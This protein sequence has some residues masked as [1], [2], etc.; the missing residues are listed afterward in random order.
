MIEAG[1]ELDIYSDQNQ[2]AI[3]SIFGE[4]ELDEET[5]LPVDL[6]P[7]RGRPALSKPKPQVEKPPMRQGP[8]SS[9]MRK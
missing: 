4:V 9:S 1:W 3:M 7:K 5:N 2:E 8:P 6:K